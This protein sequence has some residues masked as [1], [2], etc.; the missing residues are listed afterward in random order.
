MEIESSQ[1][2]TVFFK[3]K[4]KSMKVRSL[5]FLF[6]G[7]LVVLTTILCDHDSH[8]SPKK[9]FV[10]IWSLHLVHCN[11]C[12]SKRTTGNRYVSLGVQALHGTKALTLCLH[13]A[14][15][16]KEGTRRIR[17]FVV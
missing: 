15:V 13:T 16:E 10:N 8:K 1:D 4:S 2:G 17:L 12:V 14:G 3:F 11:R 5:T 9:L 7:M 6:A